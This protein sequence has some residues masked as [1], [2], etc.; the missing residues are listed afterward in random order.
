MNMTW[1]LEIMYKGY[2]DPKYKEDFNKVFELIKE[3]NALSEKLDV[4]KAKECIEQSLKL[5]EQTEELLSELFS[6]SS[7]RS[8]TN[9]NDYQA[10]GEMAK[11]QIALQDTIAASVAFSKFL[12]EVDLDKLAEESE[13]IKT[14]LFKLKK[15]KDS[16]S[17]M[18]SDK[19]EVLASKLSMVA[20]SSWS[21]LQSQA[22]AN[23]M[24][25]V[26]GFKEKLSLSAVRNLAYSNSSIERKNAYVAEL[27]AYKQVED[28]VAMAL[29]N[30]K[31]EVN[32][33]MPLRGYKDALD[34]TLKQSNISLETLNAMIEAIKEEA[35]KFREYFKLKAKALGYKKGLPFYELFA[36]MGKLTKTYSFDEAKDL[37]L[38]VYKSFSDPLY[39]MGKKAFE[40]RWID[41]LPHEGKVGGAFCAGLDNHKQS[42][43]LTNFTGSLGDV[44]TLA[45]EL[46]HAY[47]GQV[48]LNNAILNRN[49]PMPLAETASI[50]CQTLMAKKMINDI[51]DPYEKLTVVEQ[52][53]QEDSQCVIDILSRYIFETSVLDKP[54]SQPLSASD[55]CEM[56]L[57]AQDESYGDGLDKNYRHPYMWL[58]KGHYYSAGLNFYNW[59][60]AFGLLYG[61]GLYKEYIKDKVKFVKNYDTML[62]NTALMSVEDV[63]KSMG[64]DVTKKDFWIESLKF[65]EEDI[66]LFEALLKECQLIK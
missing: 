41:V 59:P 49:Y 1:D 28:A 19:E 56:M 50:L 62:E 45:H 7:L 13:L 47:H 23:L 40:E 18:L 54:I 9:V 6:Y 61:K 44:Q 65:I 46:G 29:N 38:D 30:I 24:I 10:M 26:K 17:H 11:L 66:D 53:L 15:E 37:V 42:R 51:T 52:S 21:D 14:Y 22:T 16:A 58:C 34:K 55:M 63:A 33:M 2:E 4:N 3:V 48:C 64:I 35:P 20:S 8:S 60:Y 32:I 57:Y 43:I 27:N 25:K 12:L 36:P 31:R 5:D 39:E